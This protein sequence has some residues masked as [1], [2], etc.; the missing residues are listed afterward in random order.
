[1]AQKSA[2]Q[3]LL[4][5]SY[6]LSTP[7]DNRAY[8]DALAQSY[9][10]GFVK[11]LGYSYPLI[12]AAIYRREAGVEDVPVLDV[13]CGTGIVAEGLGLPAE[14]IDGIDISPEMLKLAD[15][16]NVYRRLID[17]DLTKSLDHLGDTYG[18]VVSA[19]TFTH[20]HLGPEPLGK[21]LGVA[22]RGALFVIGINERHYAAHGFAETLAA[23]E[24]AGRIG[25]LKS[26]RRPIYDKAG[27]DQ[28]G[29]HAFIMQYR[30]A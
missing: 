28:S 8:Y 26:E 15:A 24:S 23:L 5:N 14:A 7:E 1:M 29:D 21:L 13:G 11:E 16:K 19:G 2:G 18:A 9:D 20:G 30:K 12:V 6:D 22:R 3:S 27:H 17:A 4:E 25:G 10:S